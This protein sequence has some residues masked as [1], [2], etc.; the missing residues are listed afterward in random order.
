MLKKSIALLLAVILLLPVGTLP[1]GAQEPTDEPAPPPIEEEATVQAESTYIVQEGDTLE[2]IAEMFGVTVEAIMEANG[3]V[4]PEDIEVGQELVIPSTSSDEAAGEPTEEPTA[5]PTE[6]P[7][8][9]PTEEPTA[10]PTEEPTAE[11]T[12]EPTAEPTEEPTAEPTEEPTEE[13]TAEPTEEPTAEPTEEPTMGAQGDIGAQ[14]Y[15]GSWTSYVAVQSMGTTPNSPFAISWYRGGEASPCDTT[16]DTLSPGAAKLFT[17]PGGCSSPFLGSAVVE[18]SDPVAAVVTTLGSVAQLA[19][20]YVGSSTP[21]TGPLYLLMLSNSV[22]DSQIGILNAGDAT[23]NVRVSL[24]QLDGSTAYSETTTILAGSSVH[25]NPNTMYPYNGTPGTLWAGS[26]SIENIGT[27]QPLYAVAK[28]ERQQGVMAN[29]VSVAFESLTDADASNTLLAPV[30]IRRLSS[31][32]V[33]NGQNAT[34]GVLN[35]SATATVDVTFRIFDGAT[36]FEYTAIPAT[37]PPNGSAYINT[38]DH[39]ADVPYSWYGSIRIEATGGTVL[40]QVQP[41]VSYSAGGN[42]TA[43]S[44]YNPVD[45]ALATDTI[46]Y[47]AIHKESSGGARIGSGWCTSVQVVNVHATQAATV[48]LNL[49]DSAGTVLYTNDKSVQP[50]AMAY[51]YTLESYLDA[52]LGTTSFFGGGR[53]ELSSGPTNSLVGMGFGSLSSYPNTDAY[54][55][56]NAFNQ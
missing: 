33:P 23:A 20:D 29:P 48:T 50:G 28:A 16:D 22:Y 12:E 35:P 43:W 3:L 7:T 14:A 6:E 8:V 38:R 54:T 41:W 18:A 52:S 51:W 39:M 34:V 17:V 42:Y 10:E 15:S 26:V 47:P 56:Y 46:Y 24:V 32:G 1:V 31:P 13:P 11:P 44:V 9:E 25:L 36:G 49:Y 5:E 55:T 40:G 2:S 4:S 37:L 45:P 53:V 30:I 21:S 19:S 27:P